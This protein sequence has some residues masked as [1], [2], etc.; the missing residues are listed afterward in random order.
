M[1]EDV[2]LVESLEETKRTAVSVT[3]Q[4]KAAKESEV[5]DPHPSFLLNSQR[6]EQ[7]LYLVC[8]LTQ[9][10][11]QSHPALRK[12]RIGKAQ[13]TGSCSISVS[14]AF[15]NCQVRLGAAREVYRPVASRGALMYFLIDSL[16][17]L[18]RTYYFSMATFVA[19]LQK[20]CRLS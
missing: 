2:E 13:K 11:S 18:D 1:L 16:P 12:L 14:S 3:E 17:S 10:T 15:G 19:I 5:R 6:L 20:G 7:L 8:I 4:V 9:S